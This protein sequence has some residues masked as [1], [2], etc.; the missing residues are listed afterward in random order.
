LN[1]DKPEGKRWSISSAPKRFCLLL[2]S[3]FSSWVQSACRRSVWVGRTLKEFQKGASGLS[4]E[5]KAGL[6]APVAA[7]AT[8]E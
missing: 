4:D 5:L 6:T 1:L 3:A 7:D 8:K 2:P